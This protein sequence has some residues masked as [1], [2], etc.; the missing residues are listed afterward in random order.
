MKE[1]IH[2]YIEAH[3]DEIISLLGK[4]V[5]IPSVRG[6]AGENAPFGTEC[7]RML[8]FVNDL[9]ASNG[10]D[11][12]IHQDRGYMLA[13]Y[14]NGEKALG[15]FGHADVVPADDNWLFAKPFEMKNTDGILLGRGVRDDKGGVL[16][17]YY[18]ARLIKELNIP[19]KHRLLIFTGVNEES[20]MADIKAYMQNEIPPELS[21]VPDSA[22]PCFIGDKGLYRAWAKSRLPFESIISVSGGQAFNIVLGEATAEVKY[23]DELYGELL[24]KADDTLT[25]TRENDKI[26]LCGK[27]ISTH[28][29]SPQAGKNAASVIFTSLIECKSFNANDKKR[30]A[31]INMLLTDVYG[32]GLEIANDDEAFG[33]LT[34]ANGMF[35]TENGKVNI[36]VDIRF[37]KTVDCDMLKKRVKESFELNGFEYEEN[38]FHPS[39]LL[40]KE[41]PLADCAVKNFRA[42][43]GRNEDAYI[44][45]GITYAC[46]LP[47]AIEIGTQIGYNPPFDIPAGHG[48]VHQPDEW[49]SIKG[50]LEA[51][52]LTAQIVIDADAI[53]MQHR[54]QYKI[55]SKSTAQKMQ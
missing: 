10:F 4:A 37:G 11:T 43:T 41:H 8:D 3:R 24:E 9:Y 52:E 31:Y 19:L 53:E 42:F 21:L 12:E 40:N 15:I 22:F 39:F 20:G 35:R 13:H 36:S 16:I 5:A 50:L 17:A 26:I 23:S 44:N 6:E 34:V 29:A 25:V 32:E 47:N 54:T 55:S 18:V 48:Y 51:I 38:D 2:A 7:A 45:L 30:L 14:G 1:K 28:A 33:K 49:I 27:G 46:F